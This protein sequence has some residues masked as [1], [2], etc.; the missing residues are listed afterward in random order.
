MRVFRGSDDDAALDD[1][2]YLIYDKDYGRVTMNSDNILDGFRNFVFNK[3]A[4]ID[5][6]LGQAVCAAFAR[7]IGRI[8][9]IM[10]AHETRMYSSSLLFIFEGDGEA[11]RSAI[12]TN[13]EIVHAVERKLA[14][15]TTLR[16]DSGI[17]MGD[18]DEL[19]HAAVL[20]NGNDEQDYDDDDDDMDSDM[21]SSPQIFSLKLI[22][23]AHAQWTPGQGPDENLLKGVRSLRGIFEQLAG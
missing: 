21:E 3:A 15:R 10:E 20:G 5:E 23:F 22:D 9:D 8:Q 1:E 18:D 4:G 17:A 7:E 14:T 13:N 2:G 6:D 19:I 12:E 16:T 11:L